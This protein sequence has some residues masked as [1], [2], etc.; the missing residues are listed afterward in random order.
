MNS[1]TAPQLLQSFALQQRRGNE[2][3]V[4]KLGI[5][6]MIF[7]GVT[8]IIFF[9]G[10]IGAVFFARWVRRKEAKKPDLVKTQRQQEREA[11]AEEVESYRRMVM[12]Q[13]WRPKVSNAGDAFLVPM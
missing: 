1:S 2:S 10:T 11:S 5:E 7:L 4:Q 13:D 3:D 8:I 12:A 9:I 6:P